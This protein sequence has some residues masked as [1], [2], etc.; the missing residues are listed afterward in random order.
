MKRSF[1]DVLPETMQA[2]DAAIEKFNE[3][4]QTHERRL[5]REAAAKAKAS[6]AA[7]EA[8]EREALEGRRD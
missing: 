2:E 8:A 1:T 6:D 4:N 7:V 5:K 3:G